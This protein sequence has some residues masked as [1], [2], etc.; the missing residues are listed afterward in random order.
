M[1]YV[2]PFSKI[3]T[4]T[5]RNHRYYGPTE[6]NK[7]RGELTETATDLGTIFGEANTINDSVDALASGYLQP[8]GSAYSLYDLQ[9]YMYSLESRLQ[10]R[11]YIQAKQIQ[12]LE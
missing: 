7:F 5:K 6:S 8:E 3:V 9:R 4:L 12:I 11:I 2:E 1:S 10:N